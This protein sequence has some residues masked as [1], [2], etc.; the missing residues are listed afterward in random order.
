M[1]KMPTLFVRLFDKHHNVTTTPEVTKGCEWVL[2][3][4]GIPTRK[5]DGTCCLIQ[6]GKIYKRFDYKKGRIL[7]D[8]AIPCQD[9]PDPITGSFPHWVECLEDN[10]ADKWHLEAYKNQPDLSDGTYELCGIHIQNNVDHVPTNSDILIKHG[11]YILDLNP[12]ERTYEGIRDYLNNHMIEGI[13]FHRGNGEMC[14]I[15]RSDF[16]FYWGNSKRH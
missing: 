8:G 14:K 7:P 1:K 15:K 10:P 12:W 3:G 6:D 9:V 4:E 16:G 13:V 11:S 2:N 5:F